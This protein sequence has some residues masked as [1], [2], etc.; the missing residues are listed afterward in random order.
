MNMTR[1]SSAT[2]ALTLSAL[3]SPLVAQPPSVLT[4]D[5]VVYETKVGT[6]GELFADDGLPAGTRV[7]ALDATAQGAL[8][9]LLVPSTDDPAFDHR[10]VLLYDRD[11][12]TVN[13][14]WEQRGV[15]EVEVRLA[16]FDGTA[17]TEPSTLISRPVNATIGTSRT[18]TRD[19]HSWTVANG[20]ATPR[21]RSILHLAWNDE[22]GD[23]RYAPL[24]FIDGAFAGW[25]ESFSLLDLYDVNPAVPPGTPGTHLR[26]AMSIDVGPAGQHIQVAA[27]DARSGHVVVLH[28]D[29]QPLDLAFFAAEI[30]VGLEALIGQ[31]Q[32][33][34][35]AS[36]RGPMRSVILVGGQNLG[37]DDSIT[38]FVADAVVRWADEWTLINPTATFEAFTEALL[39]VVNDLTLAL[40][41]ASNG[42]QVIE[43]DLDDD[44]AVPTQRFQ[45]RVV[46]EYP[47][48]TTGDGLHR[49]FTS[50]DGSR[51]LIAWYEAATSSVR[52]LET[53]D[54]PAAPWGPA[55]SIQLNDAMTP[56]RVEKLLQQ[57][58]R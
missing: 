28:V 23:A 33:G 51:V 18:V 20:G 45:V 46:S 35:A 30:R 22:D 19:A 21:D 49:I 9:R 2:I 5:G 55:S 10:P 54:D 52:Y 8:T 36:I 40:F 31:Y 6:Y 42:G 11:R 44:V 32:A 7:L 50:D 38:T 4:N 43:L 29:I 41:S 53:T 13:V 1:I 12:N 15:G 48:P 14:I 16:R 24:I 37:L 25:S 34:S 17:W 58:I 57:R 47:A 39:D 3:A 27:V 26:E 56:E